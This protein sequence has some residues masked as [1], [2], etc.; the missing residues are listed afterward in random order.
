M[1]GSVSEE[2]LPAYLVEATFRFNRQ[3]ACGASRP[4]WMSAIPNCLCADDAVDP[5]VVE[6]RQAGTILVT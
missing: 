2:H 4:A 5:M 1:Q 6:P 3:L